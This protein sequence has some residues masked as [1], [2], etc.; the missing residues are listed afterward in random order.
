MCSLGAHPGCTPRRR[1]L[2]ISRAV[3]FLPGASRF[4]STPASVLRTQPSPVVVRFPGGPGTVTVTATVAVT[5][6]V[7]AGSV[8]VTVAVVA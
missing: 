3:Q 8:A 2:P 6:V 5:V 1:K 7:R 4:R